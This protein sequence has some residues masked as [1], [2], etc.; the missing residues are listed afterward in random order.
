MYFE[1]KLQHSISQIRSV[2]IFV[3]P[4]DE[5]IIREKDWRNHVV[6]KISLNRPERPP[7]HL[8]LD[9]KTFVSTRMAT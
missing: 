6:P 8:M 1:C 9:E 7:P 3:K 5:Q 4:Y 2:K